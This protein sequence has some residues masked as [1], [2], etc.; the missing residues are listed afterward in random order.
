MKR[1]NSS[2]PL[3]RRRRQAGATM[4][5]VLVS[6]VIFAFGMLGIAGLQSKAVSLSQASLMRSQASALTDDIVDRMRA[7]RANAMAGNWNT[8]ADDSASS[9]SATGP[10]YHT[11]L[12]AWKT[13]LEAVLPEGRARVTVTAGVVEVLITWNDS[14]GRE[15]A[16][17]FQTV[18]R[19]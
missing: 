18:T 3:P 11:D 7:D 6:F 8:S 5:E 19:L 9:I 15:D 13:E 14:R 4:I 12:R 1:R 17:S 10:L 16:T 2:K